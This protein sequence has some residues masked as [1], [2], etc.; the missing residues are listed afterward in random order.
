MLLAPIVEGLE[1]DLKR[2]AAIGGDDTRKAAEILVESLG[3]S[4]RLR[5]LDALQQAADELTA[6]LPGT[7]VE[8]RLQ[9][10]DPVLSLS[11]SSASGAGAESADM[12]ERGDEE[13]ARIT[14]RL[15]EGLKGQIERAASR[16]GISVNGWLVDAAAHVLRLPGAPRR[17]PKRMTGFVRG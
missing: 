12:G 11:I 13:V 7:S 14:L 2:A 3:S 10:R 5:I 9:G 8:V 17:G 6:S 4:I 16:E 15:P 1:E